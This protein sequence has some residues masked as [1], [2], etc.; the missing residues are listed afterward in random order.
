MAITSKTIGIIGT[1]LSLLGLAG[2]SSAA[3]TI[4]PTIDTNPLR[5]EVAATVLAQ[6][7]LDLALTPSVNPLPPPT[8][9]VPLTSTPTQATTAPS[10]EV[11]SVTATVSSLTPEAGTENKA[12]WVSQSVADKTVFAPGETFTMTWRLKNTGTS[13]W[14]ANYI[15]R[16]YSGDPFG[17]AKEVPL[18]REVPPGETVDIILQMKAPAKLGTYTSVW[19]MSTASRSN[20]KEPVYLQN[21]V[22]NP[23]TPTPTPTP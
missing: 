22:A 1:W 14:T 19:V 5:T 9:I 7:T 2:C 4:A 3:P 6:V 17:S 18:N 23:A 21:V 10:T 13:T 15:L 8:T 11:I 16:F 12:E 20:F